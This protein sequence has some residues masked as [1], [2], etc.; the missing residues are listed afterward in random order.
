MT[1]RHQTHAVPAGPKDRHFIVVRRVPPLPG[2][3]EFVVAEDG[4]RGDAVGVFWSQMD[5]QSYAAWREN[6]VGSAKSKA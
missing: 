1:I 3:P 4:F 2:E 5:A 6:P